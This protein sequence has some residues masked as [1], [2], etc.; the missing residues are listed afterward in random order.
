MSMTGKH[1]SPGGAPSM[2]ADA[3]SMV[4]AILQRVKAVLGKCE[5]GGWKRVR[6]CFGVEDPVELR[7]A[8]GGGRSDPHVFWPNSSLHLGDIL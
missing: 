3:S 5:R 4:E 2:K 7:R 8:E 1:T 6:C